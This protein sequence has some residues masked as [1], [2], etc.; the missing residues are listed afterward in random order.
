MVAGELASVVERISE[1]VSVISSI[2]S[3]TNLLALNATI[4]AARAGEAGRGFAVVA[5]E[6]KELSQGTSR[7]ATEIAELVKSIEGVTSSVTAATR[8]IGNGLSSINETTM[9]IAAA[10]TEQEQVTRDIA[11]N[12]DA[13]SHRSDTIRSGFGD[14]R[15]AI[16]ETAV[17]AMRS[18]AS[19]MNSLHPRMRSSANSRASSSGWQ[20]RLLADQAAAR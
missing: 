1:A 2:A 3:Q 5:S 13:A 14:V 10:V 11:A 6:V 8:E 19:R 16:E 20:P 15:R 17:A 9:V 18:T 12:A 4:E 7:A